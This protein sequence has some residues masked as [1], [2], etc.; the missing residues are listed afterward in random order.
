MQN[1]KL[2]KKGYFLIRIQKGFIEVGHC[3][4]DNVPC[5]LVKGKNVEELIYKIIDLGLISDL[6]HAAYL[7]K[8]VQK[9][10][11]CLKLGKNYIQDEVFK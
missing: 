5:K 1:W 3:V 4:N 2:D 6:E 11:V 9:A 8:E 10:F 7:G